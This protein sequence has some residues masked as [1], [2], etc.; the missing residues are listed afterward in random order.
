VW[1]KGPDLF[2]RSIHKLSANVL[3]ALFRTF[4]V[5]LVILVPSQTYTARWHRMRDGIEDVFQCVS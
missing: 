3:N 4:M 2:T 5:I 1:F